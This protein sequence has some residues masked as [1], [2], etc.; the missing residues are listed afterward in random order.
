[1]E[2][3]MEPSISADGTVKE[4]LSAAE[5]VSTV[6]CRGNRKP[7]F[8]KNIGVITS[9]TSATKFQL[10]VQFDSEKKRRQELESLVDEL[11]K[12]K[13]KAGADMIKCE[14]DF[15]RVM[16]DQEKTRMTQAS[17]NALLKRMLAELGA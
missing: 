9:H 8:L 11:M 10:Q 13:E 14:Q 3:E 5:A 1:M 4:P 7:N 16:K 15:H 12:P 6:L 2:R 17:C